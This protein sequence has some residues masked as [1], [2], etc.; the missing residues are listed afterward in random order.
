MESLSNGVEDQ[1]IEGLKFKL[2]PGSAYVTDRRKCTFWASGSNIYKPL[3]GTK[4]VRF[5]LN[6]EDGT[7][8]DPS[9][10]RIQFALKNNEDGGS[11]KV[12]RPLGG[13]H[14]FFRRARVMVGNQLAE[15]ILDYNRC[16]EQFFSLM[17]DSVRDNIDI[18]GFGYRWDDKQNK[19]GTDWS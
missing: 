14:L 1:L 12:V 16:H 17:P 7:W 4:V 10:I 19:W 9:S 11:N 8:L 13:P 6:G 3:S 18:G 2:L 5:L 15:D